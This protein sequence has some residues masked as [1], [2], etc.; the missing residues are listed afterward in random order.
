MRAA[1]KFVRETGKPAGI[2]NLEDA[3]EIAKGNKGTLIVPD[4][5]AS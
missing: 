4:A 3:A 5:T 1:C 2:G